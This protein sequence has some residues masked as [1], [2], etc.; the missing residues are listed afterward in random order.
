MY[1]CTPATCFRSSLDTAGLTVCQTGGCSRATSEPLTGHVALCRPQS[2]HACCIATADGPAG[3]ARRRR[4]LAPGGQ[5]LHVGPAQHGAQ[6][7]SLRSGR[8]VAC[9]R[10]TCWRSR[11]RHQRAP[12]ADV[13]LMRHPR[14]RWR[15]LV[16]ALRHKRNISTLCWRR[17]QFNA[18]EALLLCGA[19]RAEH[20]VESRRSAS[21]KFA[22]HVTF[23]ERRHVRCL[24]SLLSCWLMRLVC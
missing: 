3:S 14:D 12:P 8:S 9:A 23:G 13:T 10:R 19:A 22:R 21:K 5:L 18:R 17:R 11:W 24:L 2:Q 1:G 7:E 20:H 6:E 4:A 16:P 15:Y